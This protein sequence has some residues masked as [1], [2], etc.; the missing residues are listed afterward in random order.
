MADA[1]KLKIDIG[2]LAAR[3]LPNHMLAGTH[4]G[5]EDTLATAIAIPTFAERG[6]KSEAIEAAAALA[7]KRDHH[8]GWTSTWNTVLAL[9][10]YVSLLLRGIA[11]E[12]LSD[13]IDRALIVVR[14][15]PTIEPA[16]HELRLSRAIVLAGMGKKDTHL[17]DA[18]MLRARAVA[19]RGIKWSSSLETAL[20]GL[21]AFTDLG[22]VSN[23]QATRQVVEKQID[24]LSLT[25]IDAWCGDESVEVIARAGIVLAK[26]GHG[27]AAKR[28]YEKACS[29]HADRLDTPALKHRIELGARIYGDQVK[30]PSA[31]S[32]ERDDEAVA[33]GKNTMP[34]QPEKHKRTY[35]AEPDIESN[36]EVLPALDVPVNKGHRVSAIVIQGGDDKSVYAT[37]RAV[38]SQDRLPDEVIAVWE[39]Q[40]E[41][42]SLTGAEKDV[43][44][45]IAAPN[46]STG[47]RWSMG[48]SVAGGDWIWMIPSGIEPDSGVLSA[49]TSV[50]KPKVESVHLND[51]EGGG[52]KLDEL[53]LDPSVQPHR[54]L[55]RSQLLGDEPFPST[56]RAEPFWHFALERLEKASW[57]EVVGGQA[58]GFREPKQIPLEWLA[59]I[60]DDRFEIRRRFEAKSSEVRR[61]RRDSITRAR[62]NAYEAFRTDGVPLVS[63]IIPHFNLPEMLVKCLESIIAN[64]S[65]IPFEVIVVDNGSEN[66]TEELRKQLE[67]WGVLLLRNERN[68]GFAPA[69]NRGALSAKGEYVL[70]LNNDTEVKEG[71]LKAMVHVLQEEEK[72][73][74]A[75][76]MLLY[77]NQTI[78]HVGITFQDD[79]VPGLIYGKG[80]VTL[81]HIHHRRAYQAV[82]GACML[83]R[84][85]LYD[86]LGG[87]DEGYRNGFEDVDFCLRARELGVKIYY[88][89]RA[90][91]IHETE[92]TPGRKD[93]DNEN[94]ERFFER[95]AG[96][97]K[98]D[99]KMYGVLDGYRLVRQDGGDVLIPVGQ[100]AAHT[101]H[102]GG[103]MEQVSSTLSTVNMVIADDNRDSG[104]S[105]NM[106]DLLAR[107]DHLIK[108]GRFD[109]AER[110]LIEGRERV[111]GNVKQRAQYWTLL[112]DTRFRLNRPEEAHECYLKAVGDDPSSERAWIGIGTYHLVNGE[113]AEANEIFSKVIELSPRNNRGHIGRGNVELRKG[114]PS[115]ALSHFIEAARLKPGYRPA[116]VGLV[117]A[118]V[119]AENM[120]KARDPL[121]QYLDINPDDIEARF[122]LAAIYFGSEEQELAR[123]EAMKVLKVKP[124]HKGAKELLSHLP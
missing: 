64:T 67:E 109:E 40:P 72:A 24:E 37:I 62:T 74:I 27:D 10:A 70:F 13:I 31:D 114:N 58:A 95:W 108:D 52:V 9:E 30:E 75:G 48:A 63:V 119:E 84:K 66:T 91:V 113:L 53:R 71:W 98:S 26:L 76:A 81:P 121:V 105:V 100:P 7:K 79:A 97:I 86:R 23:D 65:E 20:H 15:K 120:Q 92:A 101:E 33:Q 22:T 51:D 99:F 19:E 6:F 50:I 94:L 18:G 3:I 36:S 41:L 16:E 110:A 123:D 14:D 60:I 35:T 54:V 93:H 1:A 88:E 106:L 55:F 85:S 104:S 111:N 38:T 42:Q 5:A 59:G 43:R 90:V 21:L 103:N 29:I 49:L 44:H 80:P 45:L 122:H 34:E 115:A 83:V 96:K 73:E 61:K 77:P 124:E 32:G 28:A 69:C 46:D 17:I 56:Y 2:E 4:G 107:A 102:R 11:F 57:G 25:E 87:F 118:A 12:G 8:G 116:I 117:A 78:Q 82:T 112:G 47:E 39:N 68:E 89:P